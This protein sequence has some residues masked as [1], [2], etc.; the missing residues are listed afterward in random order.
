MRG[1]NRTFS[2]SGGCFKKEGIIFCR[3]VP[4]TD[5]PVM[6]YRVVSVLFPELSRGMVQTFFCVMVLF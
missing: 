4:I 5:Y 3:V 2:V 1:E 6:T